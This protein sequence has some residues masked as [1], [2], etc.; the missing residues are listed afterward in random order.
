MEVKVA[1]RATHIREKQAKTSVLWCGGGR[2]KDQTKL[3]S[4]APIAAAK[5]DC[6]RCIKAKKAAEA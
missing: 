6:Q 3:K 2:C 1:K 4:V 5:G